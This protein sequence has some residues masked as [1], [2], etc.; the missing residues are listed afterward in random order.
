MSHINLTMLVLA[1]LFD[2]WALPK[3]NQLQELV[4]MNMLMATSA[5][6]SVFGPKGNTGNRLKESKCE[7]ACECECARACVCVCAC[8]RAHVCECVLRACCVRVL[9][10]VLVQLLAF[11]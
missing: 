2:N 7:C 11:F 4:M 3:R 1:A 5:S 9:V 6:L 10:R 8:V